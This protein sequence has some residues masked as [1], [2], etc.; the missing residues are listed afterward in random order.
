MRKTFIVASFI[1]LLGFGCI[2]QN[3]VGE[4]KQTYKNTRYGFSLQYPDTMVI[5]EDK[6][7]VSF[8]IT[9]ST[10][11]YSG[12]VLSARVTTSSIDS[13]IEE[14][15]QSLAESLIPYL[16]D[17]LV[18][19]DPLP[20]YRWNNPTDIGLDEFHYYFDL[21]NINK[22]YITFIEAGDI[23]RSYQAIVQSL[24]RI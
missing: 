8:F 6:Q 14:I 13:F 3:Y 15:R 20:G 9:S 12:P 2:R 7:G 11:D 10:K 1:T 24:K 4:N 19:N 18:V 17:P 16:G 22:L 23:S 21:D 5:E